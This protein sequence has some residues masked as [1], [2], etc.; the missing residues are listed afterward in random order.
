MTIKHH[1]SFLLLLAVMIA[2]T[3]CE[4]K[5]T[6]VGNSTA[7]TSGDQNGATSDTTASATSANAGDITKQFEDA[8]RAIVDNCQISIDNVPRKCK[9]DEAKNL[10]K[11]L[12]KE[13]LALYPAVV[14]TLAGQ[15]LPM[16]RIAAY[17]LDRHMYYWLAGTK[18]DGGPDKETTK[19]LLSAVETFNPRRNKLAASTIRFAIDAATLAGMHAEARALLTRFDPGA[20]QYHMW[21]YSQGLRRTMTYGR[22]TFFDLIKKEADSEHDSIRMAA[23]QAPNQMSEW[24]KPEAD[25]ICPWAGEYIKQPDDK[26]NG[27]P[28]RL[29]LRCPDATQWRG[30]L[31]DEATR[32]L[33]EGTYRRP[34]AFAL[35]RICEAPVDGRTPAAGESVCTR[36]EIFLQRVVDN[37]KI[38]P[39]ERAHAVGA[40]AKQFPDKETVAFLQKHKGTKNPVL[41]RRV[42]Q[43]LKNLNASTKV[44]TEVEAQKEKLEKKK[45]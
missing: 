18:A 37:D 35:D 2:L 31:L 38:K 8:A 41:A 26:T 25:Q 44:N 6:D 7:A 29:L 15:D 45:Q 13:Q 34:F 23:F 40:L 4:K 42:D 20:S 43:E 5:K 21:V 30:V 14:N 12:K 33:N 22:L 11:L 32:R 9:G 3:G 1:A 39:R 10:V 24:T 28:A 19:K 27:G 17:S 16:Q 36:A